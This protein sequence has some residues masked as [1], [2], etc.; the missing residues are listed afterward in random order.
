MAVQLLYVNVVVWRQGAAASLGLLGDVGIRVSVDR[1][2]DTVIYVF[3]F[4]VIRS[5]GG[6]CLG[7]VVGS[8]KGRRRPEERGTQQREADPGC[9]KGRTLEGSGQG[10]QR[11]YILAS[12][13]LAK[14]VADWLCGGCCVHP[15]RVRGRILEGSG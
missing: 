8:W 12:S 1:C 6:V 10:G 13:G 7:E 9:V 15:E 4:S 5:R 3:V 14:G 2:Q 11:N